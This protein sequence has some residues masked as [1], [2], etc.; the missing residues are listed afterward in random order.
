GTLEDRPAAG[1]EDGGLVAAAGNALPSTATDRLTAT[2]PA[3]STA[4]DNT[5][6][7]ASVTSTP[8]R[9][10]GCGPSTKLA[11]G[12]TGGEVHLATIGTRS[13][14]CTTS[15]RYS[16]GTSCDDRPMNR[17]SSAAS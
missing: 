12:R 9:V 11:Y 7:A 15:R 6:A 2:G 5:S 14:A 16:E 13:S 10:P 4:T 1:G 3:A 17:G 8:R